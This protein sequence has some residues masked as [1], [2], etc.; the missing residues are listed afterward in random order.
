MW[1]PDFL[2]PEPPPVAPELNPERTSRHRRHLKSPGIAPRRPVS[3][4]ASREGAP[5]AGAGRPAL[6]LRL[7]PPAALRPWTSF[8]Q[9]ERPGGPGRRRVGQP[10]SQLTEDAA[11]AR[12]RE[13]RPGAPGAPRRWRPPRAWMRT[14]AL[15]DLKLDYFLGTPRPLPAMCVLFLLPR[16][17]LSFSVSFFDACRLPI[18]GRHAPTTATVGGLWGSA[19][20]GGGGGAPSEL[21]P[22][23]RDP[24][25]RPSRSPEERGREVRRRAGPG[26]GPRQ[27]RGQ[28]R[29]SPARALRPSPSVGPKL[30]KLQKCAGARPPAANTTKQKAA[31]GKANMA[32]L[33]MEPRRLE[34][35][36]S[37]VSSFVYLLIFFPTP[38]TG[39][40]FAVL[41]VLS[42]PLPLY[43][44]YS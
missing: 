11:R 39:P 40:S 22:P 1:R 24:S 2:F 36:S 17:G 20:P 28:R 34:H 44:S 6:R 5:E 19:C 18:P 13:P 7:G 33:K 21:L 43:F 25:W 26:R 32:L 35:L 9:R 30:L 16:K 31:K 8:G 37:S 41:R 23:G 4:A 10:G 27:R 15:G 42:A 14:L 29:P 38:P 3:P 12:A